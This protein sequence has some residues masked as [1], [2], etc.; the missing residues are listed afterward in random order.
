MSG[1]AIFALLGI[2]FLMLGWDVAAVWA[3][4]LSLVYVFVQERK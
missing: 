1:W 3:G 2:L 4:C